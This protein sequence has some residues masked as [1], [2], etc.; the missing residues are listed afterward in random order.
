MVQ[1]AR[2][3]LG[4]LGQMEP[5][6]ISGRGIWT[7]TPAG[8]TRLQNEQ[9]LLPQTSIQTPDQPQPPTDIHTVQDQAIKYEAEIIRLQE[10]KVQT[11]TQ[12]LGI[13]GILHKF[14]LSDYRQDTY[15]YDVI[16]KQAQHLPR[17]THCFEV[18]SLAAIP[19]S[20]PKLKHA[21]D[22]WGANLFLVAT[23]EP[24]THTA[25]ARLMPHFTG[26]FQSVGAAAN[27]LT[28]DDVQDLYN[29]LNPNHELLAA[30]LAN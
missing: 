26:D 1:W 3:D 4:K 22:I 6:A 13:G 2:T 12:L 29:A 9:H 10:I 20:L 19:Q 17:A 7:I 11:Q 21:A 5:P 18:N 30:L 23:D 16:W 28:A 25:R 15:E 14:A 27:V 8:I 24:K